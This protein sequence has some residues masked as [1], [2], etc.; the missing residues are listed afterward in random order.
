MNRRDGQRIKRRI[1][2]EFDYEGHSHAGIVVDLSARGVFLQTERIIEPGSVLFVRLRPER[3]P[4]VAVRG[5]VVRRRFTPAVLAS[6][7]RRGV[8]LRLADVPPAYFE[9]LGVAPEGDV[10]RVFGV[11]PPG[12]ADPASAPA[13][14]IVIDLRVHAGESLV[15]IP[16]ADTSAAPAPEGPEAE[17]D[18]DGPFGPFEAPAA[19]PEE[20]EAALGGDWETLPHEVPES[21]S[22]WPPSL[23]R[24]DA[25]LIDEGELD[26]VHALLEALGADPLRQRTPELPGFSFSGWE[27]P[28]RLVVAGARSALRLSVGPNVEAQ[29]IVTI[30]ILDSASQTLSGMLRRQGFRYLVRRPVH[31]EALKLLLLR[32]LFRGRERREAPRVPLGCEIA[33][34]LGLAR[35]PATLL[36]LSRSGCRLLSAEWLDPG[37]RL[38]LRIPPAVTGNRPLGLAARVVRSER[39]RGAEPEQRV[40]LALRFDRLGGEQRARLEALLA[41][42]ALGPPPLARDESAEAAR[43]SA[44]EALAESAADPAA[45]ERRRGPRTPH[46]MEVLALDPDLRRVRHALL[47]VDLS[48]SGI[49]VEPHPDLARGDCVKLALYDAACDRSLT[50]EAEVARDDGPRG[51]W[52]RFAA[53]DSEAERSLERILARA[54]QIES[55]ASAP[56]EGLVVA[57]LLSSP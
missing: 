7:I 45:P 3:Q 12:D 24:A 36:E 25:L 8:G 34:R 54:P 28:P 16:L 57:E 9:L 5:C 18:E 41:A 23:H 13:G 4:E 2:C 38:G 39:R 20:P 17:D 29:G 51:L 56:G 22:S 26:D 42:H 15:A 40:A 47:G 21:A 44:P 10:E 6:M 35:K 43:D 50:V 11:V 30:A 48:L 46:R 32:A 52:L 14:P 27:Q 55:S 19:A 49:R 53:L 31:R 1:P 37:D 33:L